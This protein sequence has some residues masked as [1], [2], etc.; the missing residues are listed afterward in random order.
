MV[1]RTADARGTWP[2]NRNSLQ[3]RQQLRDKRKGGCR[4]CGATSLT[5][6]Y[7]ISQ[8]MSCRSL[9]CAAVLAVHNAMT[10]SRYHTRRV[11]FPARGAGPARRRPHRSRGARFDAAGPRRCP[12]SAH[13]GASTRSSP[14]STSRP[15]SRPGSRPNAIRWAIRSRRRRLSMPT[16]AVSWARSSPGLGH[17][18][19]PAHLHAR[20]H[21][22]ASTPVPR[23]PA[24]ERT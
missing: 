9:A 19:S 23:I 4:F 16:S 12:C 20:F 22:G 17:G 5:P 10:T 6:Y 24:I 7:Q 11:P 13:S 21:R 14:A 8:A 15:A 2:K 18:V 3:Q 1:R